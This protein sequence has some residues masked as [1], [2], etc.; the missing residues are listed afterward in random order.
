MSPVGVC[1]TW[2]CGLVMLAAGCMQCE[3]V[4]SCSALLKLARVPQLT[5]LLATKQAGIHDY[6]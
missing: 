5:L 4:T 2:S 1:R 6:F 3:A